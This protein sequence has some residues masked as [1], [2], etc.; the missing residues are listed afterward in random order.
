[1]QMTC[2]IDAKGKMFRLI[3]GIISCSFGI[4]L[5]ILI[6]TNIITSTAYLLPAVGSILGG[7]FAVWEARAGWCLVRSLGIKTPI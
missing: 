1:M 7:I 4:S 2:N 5:F 3:T 6:N